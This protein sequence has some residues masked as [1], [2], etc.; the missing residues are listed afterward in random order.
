MARREFTRKTRALA[1]ARCKGCCEGVGCGARLKAG[2]AEYDHILPSALGGD[3]TLANCQVLCKV[4]HRGPNGKTTDDI[5]RIRKAD[6]QRDRD[7]GAMVRRGPKMQGR[8]FA[9]RPRPAPKAVLAP[10]IIFAEK[11]QTR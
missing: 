9:K 4:C 8:Q 1:F 3:I 11:E 6:R 10:K 5:R 7:T 2:E